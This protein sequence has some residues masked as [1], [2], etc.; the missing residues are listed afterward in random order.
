M[1][2]SL[3]LI[4]ILFGFLSIAQK[5]TTHT[6]SGYVSDAQSGEALIGVKIFVP[7]INKGTISNTYGFYSLTLEEGTYQIQFRSA[8]FPTEIKEI[9]LTQDIDYNLERI[10]CECG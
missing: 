9:Q 10:L 2:H 6:I 7:A 3:T 1:K 8:L 5:N 4:F